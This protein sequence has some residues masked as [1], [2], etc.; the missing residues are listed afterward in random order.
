MYL[1]IV[2]WRRNAQGKISN[3]DN[4]IFNDEVAAFFALCI[5]EI[6]QPY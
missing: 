1:L 3:K 6:L 2:N 4:K 5:L